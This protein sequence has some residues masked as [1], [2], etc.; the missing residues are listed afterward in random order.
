MTKKF[1]IYK[2]EKILLHSDLTEEEFN[3]IWSELPLMETLYMF[4]EI[5]SEDESPTITTVYN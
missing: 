1:N 5:V 2:T 4:D 3:R